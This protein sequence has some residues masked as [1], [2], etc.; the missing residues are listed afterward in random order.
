MTPQSL[1]LD[2]RSKRDWARWIEIGLLALVLTGGTKLLTAILDTQTNVER[3][4]SRKDGSARTQQTRAM[5]SPLSEAT[6]READRVNAI[7]DK[8]TV[9][10][11]KLFRAVETTPRE[12]VALLSLSPDQRAGTAQV[13]GEAADLGAMFDYIDRLQKQPTLTDV[14]L[15]S[16]KF[17]E[18]D[19][20][21]PIRFTVTASWLDHDSR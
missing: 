19:P 20:Q 17:E 3:L 9:P 5:L 13:A 15:L 18:Q 16:Q 14:Y 11:D 2:F 1:H 7:I 12:R 21:H 8:L 4:E 6:L 10:W